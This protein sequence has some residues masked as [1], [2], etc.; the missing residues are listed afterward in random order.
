MTLA[1]AKTRR[2]TKP[3]GNGGGREPPDVVAAPG[4]AF[5]GET[6]VTSTP[7]E[8]DDTSLSTAPPVAG[9]GGPDATDAGETGF[10]GSRSSG[11]SSSAAGILAVVV[12]C[13]LRVPI[14]RWVVLS[15]GGT[16]Q[17]A[18]LATV[19]QLLVYCSVYI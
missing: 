9:A 8:A 2:L 15:W 14:A 3:A 10:A 6:S 7:P 16:H 19:G 4:G 13:M 12:L 17:H 1:A 5:E 11:R 18:N